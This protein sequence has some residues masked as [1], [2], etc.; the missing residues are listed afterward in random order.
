MQGNQNN[1]G[2]HIVKEFQQGDHRLQG[3]W[4]GGSLCKHTETYSRVN[5]LI[6]GKWNFK[7][8]KTQTAH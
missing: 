5:A 6:L 2:V 4:Y 8:K 7:K 3:L 1:H